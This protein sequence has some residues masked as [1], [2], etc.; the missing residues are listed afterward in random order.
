MKKKIKKI[1]VIIEEFMSLGIWHR[2][3]VTKIRFLFCWR[4]NRKLEKTGM[5]DL[6]CGR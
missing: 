4:P 5:R 3:T 6:P 1:K 2:L